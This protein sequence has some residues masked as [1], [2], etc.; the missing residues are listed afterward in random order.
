MYS[1]TLQRLGFFRFVDEFLRPIEEL[2]KAIEVERKNYPE[3]D[4]STSLIVLPEAFNVGD[5]YVGGKCEPPYLSN[6]QLAASVICERL[7]KELAG[8]LGVCFV[9]GVLEKAPPTHV[10]APAGTPVRN[11]AYWVDAT[12]AHLI[13]HKMG[14]DNKCLYEPCSSNQDSHNPIECANAS[15]A[16]LI[17][18]DATESDPTIQNR[19]SA[20]LNTLKKSPK[21]PIICVPARTSVI[22]PDPLGFLADLPEYWYILADGKYL[23]S[24]YVCH[25]RQGTRPGEGRKVEA[26]PPAGNQVRLSS[27]SEV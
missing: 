6:R 19:R 5:G 13:C 25:A 24:S 16:T 7:R 4:I 11:S 8:P 14:N 15:I 2:A 18:M 23:T 22:G 27:L 21:Q 10:P 9:V 20:L 17:C 1:G 26:P 3:G 12:G